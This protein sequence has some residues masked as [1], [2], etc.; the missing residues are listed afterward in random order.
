MAHNSPSHG[1]ACRRWVNIDQAADTVRPQPTMSIALGGNLGK[2]KSAMI[3][4]PNQ[5]ASARGPITR[6]SAAARKRLVELLASINQGRTA[7]L[8]LFVTLTYPGVWPDDPGTWKRHLDSWCKRLARRF[9]RTSAVWKLE[10]QSRGAPHFHL[11]VFGPGW[12]NAGWLAR[13]WYETVGSGDPRHLVAGTQ[14]VRVKS[15]RGVMFYAAKYLGKVG[16]D[17][18]LVG[19]GRFWGVVGREFLPIELIEIPL[20]FGQF[21]ALRRLLI[22]WT[23]GPHDERAAN[24]KISAGC[25]RHRIRGEHQGMTVFREAARVL[26]TLRLVAR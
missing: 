3:P 20:T 17:R 23:Q 8:P 15:W 25:Y 11:L 9:T 1:R 18:S 14:V 24:K 26:Q 16:Q 22:R 13:T 21:F 5:V 10:F 4:R 19:V 7:R 2:L 12:I 6:F